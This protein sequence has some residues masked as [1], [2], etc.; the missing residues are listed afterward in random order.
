[1]K[2]F[3]AGVAVGVAGVVAGLITFGEYMDRLD[4]EPHT[5]AEWDR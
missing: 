2:R 1:M 5:W 4:E 3:L